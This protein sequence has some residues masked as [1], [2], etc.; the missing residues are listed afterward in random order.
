MHKRDFLKTL[1]LGS[2]GLAA[3]R[4]VS[5][6]ELLR[7]VDRQERRKYWTWVTTDLTISDEEWKK[8]FAA[9]RRSG[10]DAILPE[11]YDSRLA[12]YDS[13]HLPAGGAWLERL[14]PLA[15]AEGLEVHAWMWSMP[16]NVAEVRAQHPEW[17]VVNRKGESAAEKPSYVDYYR[18]LCPSRPEVHRFV[19]TTV[20]ELCRYEALDGIHLDYIRYPDV[21]LPE[22]LQPK[23]G[24][25]QE[26]EEPEYDYCYCDVCRG[27]F[28]NLAGIDPLKLEDPSTSDAWKKFRYDRITNLVNDTLIPTAHGSGKKL[29]AAVFPNWEMVR[30]QWPSW[31]LDAA[32]PMLYHSLYGKDTGWIKQQT[33]KGVR[34]LAGRAP[35]YSG[36]L[37]FR[38]SP[39]ELAK[40]VEASLAGGAQGVV[41]FPAQAMS[42]AQWRSFSQAIK[43]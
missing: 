36:I 12:Y 11:I 43:R 3:G 29:T 13:K 26:R 1:G 34:S 7:A 28:K 6:T 17:F 16:C 23:Y 10:I 42:E 14:L 24:I 39:E 2:L 21:I 19:Q 40:A 32:L 22:S 25:K 27:D 15:K 8:R 35:L 37:V 33:E 20:A 30:Q 5:A 4:L 9:M 38:L 18:F 31:D 41:L